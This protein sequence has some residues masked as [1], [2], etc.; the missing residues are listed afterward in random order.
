MKKFLRILISVLI[1]IAI[2]L[3]AGIFYITQGLESGKK[4]EIVGLDISRIQDG[5][6]NGKYESGRWSN[7]LIVT[8]NENKIIG[9]QIV[10]DVKFAQ[11]AVREE[12]FSKVIEAQN[13]K[14]DTVAGA[15]VTSKAYL[16]SI[17]NAFGN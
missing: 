3:A 14:V 1:V 11:P 4:I 17:E 15:T 16:K 12:L 13:T 9:I 10:D 5:E 2:I 7:E 6:Y 8:V